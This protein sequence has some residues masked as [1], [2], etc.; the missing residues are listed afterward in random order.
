MANSAKDSHSISQKEA[1]PLV[2]GSMAPLERQV[3]LNAALEID[4]GVSRFSL[5]AFHVR[6]S[7][8]VAPHN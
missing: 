2:V 3:A 4:S 7:S 5:R 1:M 8:N 6:L